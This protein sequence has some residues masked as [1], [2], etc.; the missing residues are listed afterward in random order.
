MYE[1]NSTFTIKSYNGD[2]CFS[3]QYPFVFIFS[4]TT[5]DICVGFSIHR[6]LHQ[7]RNFIG[8]KPGDYPNVEAYYQRLKARPSW[9]GSDV[10]V[11]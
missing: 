1:F 4:F 5:A 8:Y 2:F 9:A 11:I 7:L 10:H 3:N 6:M